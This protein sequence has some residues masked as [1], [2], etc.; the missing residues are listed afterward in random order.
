MK[1]I[2]WLKKKTEEN[3][4]IAL[5]GLAMFLLGVVIGESM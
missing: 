5:F 4:M 3:W 2:I 1:Q